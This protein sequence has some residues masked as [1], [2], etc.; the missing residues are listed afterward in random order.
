MFNVIGV[1]IAGR[2]EMRVGQAIVHRGQPRGA[3][4]AEHGELHR[5]RFAGED[6]QAIVGGVE[7][8]VNQDID[9]VAR[10]WSAT[11]GSLRP[12]MLCQ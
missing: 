6:E 12:T 3:G 10:I 9:A 2:V 7:G 8:Q 11:C 1:V 4:H 5:R